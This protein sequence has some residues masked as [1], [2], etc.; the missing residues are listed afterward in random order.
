M[1]SAGHS[2]NMFI[3]ILTVCYFH[4]SSSLKISSNANKLSHINDQEQE[5][6]Y[7]KTKLSLRA[8]LTHSLSRVNQHNY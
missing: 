1:F 8:E 7:G 4:S 5:R 3:L 2:M 6:I